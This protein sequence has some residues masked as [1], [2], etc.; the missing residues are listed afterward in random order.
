MAN[1]NLQS[2]G[3]GDFDG[4]GTVD[5]VVSY[6]DVSKVSFFMNK[7]D[8]ETFEQKDINASIGT[9]YKIE[10]LDLVMTKKWKLLSI[11]VSNINFLKYI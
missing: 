1:E 3:A 6:Q 9:P 11:L 5:L 4:N 7:G 2:I 10:V 8:G